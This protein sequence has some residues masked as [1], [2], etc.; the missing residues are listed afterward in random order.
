MVTNT[1]SQAL[2][3]SY[4]AT[5]PDC[6]L[7][8]LQGAIELR[9]RRGGVTIVITLP[10]DVHEWFVDLQDVAS[11]LKH[12][13]WYDY[14]GYDASTSEEMDRDMADDLRSFVENVSRERKLSGV[15]TVLRN[16]KHGVG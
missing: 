3:R 10:N 15:L 11:G 5:I 13:D 1:E 12:H 6:E 9:I 16:A 4:A 14:A 8:E 2:L 7:V